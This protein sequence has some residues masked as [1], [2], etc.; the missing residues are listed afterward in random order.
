MPNTAQGETQQIRLTKVPVETVR[1]IKSEAA[2]VGD[3]LDN[4][5]TGW[6][7][8]EFKNDLDE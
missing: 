4:Y 6:I 2:L 5:L 1:K 3:T 7:V 8:E